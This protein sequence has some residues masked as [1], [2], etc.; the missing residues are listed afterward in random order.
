MRLKKASI[1]LLVLVLLLVSVRLFFPVK[2]FTIEGDEFVIDPLF[3]NER[4]SKMYQSYSKCG[5]G[6]MATNN[7]TQIF[8]VLIL[9][10]GLVL[11]AQSKKN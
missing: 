1:V 4:L 2:R 7:T 8:G 6:E 9:G 3:A 5:L 10:V 11:L